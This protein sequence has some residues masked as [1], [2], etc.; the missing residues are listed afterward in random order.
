MTRRR[1]IQHGR[2][3]RLPH[4]VVWPVLVL[5]ALIGALIWELTMLFG[6]VI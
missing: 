4:S 5:V 3:R 1:N 6:A 2:A